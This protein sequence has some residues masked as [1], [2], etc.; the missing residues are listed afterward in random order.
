[1][2]HPSFGKGIPIKS[3]VISNPELSDWKCYLFGN[4]GGSG[5]TYRAPKG[6]EPN[7]IVRFF[8]KLLLDCY[9][10]KVEDDK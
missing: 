1:M 4:H 10:Y 3:D 2:K 7:F 9:W 8:M 6:C 5:L